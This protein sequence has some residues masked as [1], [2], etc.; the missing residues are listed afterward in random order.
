MDVD[1]DKVGEAVLVL[2]QLTLHG[3]VRAWKGH[4]SSSLS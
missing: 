4:S 3:G 1:T 2:L